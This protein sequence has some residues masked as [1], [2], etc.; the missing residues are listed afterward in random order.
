MRKVRISNTVWNKL[1]E[2]T[3][4]LTEN[5]KLSEEAAVR[6]ID[7]IV[8]FLAALSNPADYALCRFKRWRVLGY[9]CVVF[10]KSWVFAYEIIDDGVIVRDMSH[11]ATLIE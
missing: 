8:V 5:F 1:D 2:L 11:A 7:R 10:E 3:N 6:R 4:Y 9:R